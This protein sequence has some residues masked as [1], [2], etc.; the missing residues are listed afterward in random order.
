[1]MSIHNKGFQM[2]PL[3]FVLILCVGCQ[4]TKIMIS[5]EPDDAKIY[6]DGEYVGDGTVSY[7]LS[8]NS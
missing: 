7:S 3:A 2:I 6:V 4:T 5:A 1:M 8:G